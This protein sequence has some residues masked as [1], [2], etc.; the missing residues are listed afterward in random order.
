[1]VGKVLYRALTTTK[2]SIG[3]P[4][5]FAVRSRVFPEQGPVLNMLKMKDAGSFWRF[6]VVRLGYDS[7]VL[8]DKKYIFVGRDL[9]TIDC[10]AVVVGR[11]GCYGRSRW[12]FLNKPLW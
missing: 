6:P 12:R 7:V 8:H 9:S 11:Y 4:L 1:M 10:Q 5:Y 2:R 3:T